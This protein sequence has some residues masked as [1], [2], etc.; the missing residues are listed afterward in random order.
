MDIVTRTQELVEAYTVQF[1]AEDRGLIFVPYKSLME[2]IKKSVD[3]LQYCGGQEMTN[4][5]RQESYQDWLTATSKSTKWMVC[6]GAFAA[7]NDYPHVRV[8]IH[9]GLI[10][11]LIARKMQHASRALWP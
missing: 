9:A 7:G 2:E 8:V 3:C 10:G 4:E 11:L 5:Q 6:T 1:R